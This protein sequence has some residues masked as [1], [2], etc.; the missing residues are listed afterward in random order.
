MVN[1]NYWRLPEK[2]DFCDRQKYSGSSL[3]FFQPCPSFFGTTSTAS[4]EWDAWEVQRR[5]CSRCSRQWLSD[6][7]ETATQV[8]QVSGNEMFQH[9]NFYRWVFPRGK[10]ALLMFK[11][12]QNEIKGVDWAKK[13]WGL[14]NH[15][16][17][18]PSLGP[19]WLQTRADSLSLTTILYLLQCDG[20][21]ALSIQPGWDEGKRPRALW[22]RFCASEEEGKN[23]IKHLA[24]RFSLEC[25]LTR[26]HLIM[27]WKWGEKVNRVN[28]VKEVFNYNQPSESGETVKLGERSESVKRNRWSWWL[29][30]ETR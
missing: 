19:R 8:T 6:S 12:G 22:Y 2:N 21:C 15:F 1:S 29:I 7:G 10:W 3:S 25:F 16:H 14:F 24:I 23:D 20:Y 13:R 11:F 27:M 4:Q 9:M 26:W 18:H 28:Q 17:F 30:D 5:R